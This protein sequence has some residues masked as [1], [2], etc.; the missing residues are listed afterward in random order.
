MAVNVVMPKAGL[1]MTHGTI[2]EWIKQEG[3]RVEKGE[4]ILNIENEKT[5]IEVVSPHEGILHI[6]SEAGEEYPI[7]ETIALL[8]ESDEEYR[9]LC[10]AA[11][12][13]EEAPAAPAQS[14]APAAGSAPAPARP[15]P[16]ME[17]GRIKASPNA[18]RVAHGLGVDLALVAGTGPGGRIVER[19]V[20][21]FLKN[22]PAAPAAS[23]SR[24]P[25]RVP[26]TS[27][28]RTIAR[29]M[30]ESLRDKAQVTASVEIDVSELVA[31]H[32]KL[33]AAAEVI[34]TKITY[35]D[36][37]ARMMVPVLK[38]HPYANSGLEGD[39]I[40]LYPN[41]NL[42]IAVSV[43]NGLQV[44]VIRDVQDMSLV[45][46]SQAIKGISR[47]ARDGKLAASDLEGGTFTITNVGMFPIDFGTPII[48]GN[49]STILGLGRIIKKP[50]VM[51]NGE[52]A[53]RSMMTIFLT[54]D[55]QVYDG[56][57]AC[58]LMQ[59]IKELAEHPE[60]LLAQ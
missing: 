4:V 60:R 48:N 30:V 46:V 22:P 39:D 34:G 29:R 1:T 45:E 52:I 2:G 24:Q 8:A 18:R 53:V 36:L 35:T 17:G 3:D 42:S 9:A 14:D 49:Q 37:F 6:T 54:F 13:K 47:K 21:E 10:A 23:V 5:T 40:L 38:K 57:E 19:D 28:R 26:M 56:A 41:L 50:A 33:R 43:D 11:A 51:E 16:R 55:H 58:G 59:D 31:L 12:P 25:T 7:S 32:D 44:P 20:H 27:M 15:A